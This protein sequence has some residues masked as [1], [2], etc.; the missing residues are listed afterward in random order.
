[1]TLMLPFQSRSTPSLLVLITSRS[2][3]NSLMLRI[4]TP[5]R[6]KL[7]ASKFSIRTF[8]S[9]ERLSKRAKTT[10]KYGRWGMGVQIGASTCLSPSSQL[11]WPSAEQQK[12]MQR[13]LQL[14]QFHLT[15][16][17]PIGSWYCAA[18][19]P[20]CRGHSGDLNLRLTLST[21]KLFSPSSQS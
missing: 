9:R 17:K 4:S 7:T 18:T 5:I 19:M 10:A 3:A 1:M 13:N 2:Q 21:A 11:S 12:S 14:Q 15:K 20:A 6:R 8:L 16:R